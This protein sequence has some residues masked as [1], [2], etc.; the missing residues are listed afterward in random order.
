MIGWLLRLAASTT[1]SSWA[2]SRHAS[3]SGRRLR[4]SITPEIDRSRASCASP[5]I[6]GS[7]GFSRS[8]PPLANRMG[9]TPHIAA[10]AS[11]SPLGSITHAVRP[12]NSCLHKKVLIRLDFA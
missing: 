12:N 3:S 9:S 7:S 10:S 2:R 11:Y 5:P 4:P 8:V 1:A 6:I